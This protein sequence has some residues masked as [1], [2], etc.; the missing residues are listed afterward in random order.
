MR[1]VLATS[2]GPFQSLLPVSLL[3]MNEPVNL[4]ILALCLS[5]AN[6]VNASA[7]FFSGGNLAVHAVNIVMI[8]TAG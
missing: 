3:L 7:S 2:N 6:A 8:L 5:V 1:L 4:L